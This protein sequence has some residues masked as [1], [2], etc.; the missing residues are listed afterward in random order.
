MYDGQLAR[1]APAESELALGI[2]RGKG[3]GALDRRRRPA[4]GVQLR[5]ARPPSNGP[6]GPSAIVSHK[7]VGVP[8]LDVRR[9]VIVGKRAG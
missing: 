4:I 7:P 1:P 5:A 9:A 6:R 8:H 3:L 2:D